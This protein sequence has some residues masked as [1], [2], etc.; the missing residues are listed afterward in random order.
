M[1][2]HLLILCHTS[3]RFFILNFVHFY[4]MCV[5]GFACMDVCAPHAC[6]VCR[7]QKRESDPLGLALQIVLSHHVGS[8]NQTEIL[9]ET[10]KHS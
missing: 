2:L 6:S 7:S 10:S 8:R 5:S 1:P 3:L 9:S 4:F